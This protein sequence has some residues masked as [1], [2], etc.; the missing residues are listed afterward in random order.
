VISAVSV[1]A[2]FLA[3]WVKG[4]CGF[5]NTLVMGTIM[6]FAAD[7]VDITP[8][9]L[10]ICY[11]ANL[12]MVWRERR[13]LDKAVW[14]PL[15]VMVLLGSIPGAIVLKNADTTAIKLL[16]GAVVIYVAWDMLRREN[17]AR[18]EKA[19]RGKMLFIGLVSGVLSGLFGIGALLAA[20]V[21]RTTKDSGAF[22]ANLCMVF[23]VTNTLRFPIYL[24][25]GIL[26]GDVWRAA[27]CLMP[28]MLLGLW[29][30]TKMSSRI[31]ERTAKKVIVITLMVLGVS[32]IATNLVTLFAA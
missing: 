4:L 32:L 26:T 5:A 17:S 21:G 11:P 16:F 18:E 8:L 13:G 10:L 9:D 3:F 24:F 2:V 15:S 14:V 25:S 12:L 6:G 20:Y 19:S 23:T 31:S 29:A 28:V 1:A 7:N 30:G 22:R 27:L